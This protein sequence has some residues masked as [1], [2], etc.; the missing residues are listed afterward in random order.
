MYQV[1]LVLP[2]VVIP[3]VPEV[4][5][6]VVSDGVVVIVVTVVVTEILTK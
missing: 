5:A 6:E 1:V 3:G 2:D 4:A